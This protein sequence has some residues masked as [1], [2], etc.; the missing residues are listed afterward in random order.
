MRREAGRIAE[1]RSR[2]DDDIIEGAFRRWPPMRLALCYFFLSG[3]HCFHF[4]LDGHI[5]LCLQI[6]A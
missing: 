2:R 6:A 4:F 1:R 3:L 5:V